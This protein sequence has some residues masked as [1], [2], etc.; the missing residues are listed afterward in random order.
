MAAV[1][2]GTAHRSGAP[3]Y[4]GGT[5]RQ[6]TQQAGRAHRHGTVQLF[7]QIELL[8]KC[9]ELQLPVG[10]L[11]RPRPLVEPTLHG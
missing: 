10:S 2:A 6:R 5:Q 11:R 4:Q 9:L 8:L 3:P 1:E 7:S